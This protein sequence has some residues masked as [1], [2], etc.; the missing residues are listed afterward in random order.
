MS[1]RRQ[2]AL[3][4]TAELLAF[5]KAEAQRLRADASRRARRRLRV[6]LTRLLRRR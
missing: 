2:H 3:R 1:A 4:V 5:H 6:W